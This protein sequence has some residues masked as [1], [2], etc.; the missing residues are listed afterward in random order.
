MCVDSAIASAECYLEQYATTIA[1][2]VGNLLLPFLFSYLTHFEEY[3][4]KTQLMIDLVRNIVIRLSGLM[5][6]IGGH[7]NSNK[8]VKQCVYCLL[9]I[10]CLYR[11]GYYETEDHQQACDNGNFLN[12]SSCARRICWETAV[13]VEFYRLTVLDL[14]TQILVIISLDIWRVKCFAKLEFNIPKHVL[15]IVY[16]QTICWMGLFFAP[17]LSLITL[18][19]LLSLFY[20]RLSYLKNWCQPS[21]TFYEVNKMLYKHSS[22]NF[23]LQ[24]S[25]TSSLLNIFL[26]VSF[27]FSFIPIAYILG[28]MSPSNACG[29]FRDPSITNYSE[30]AYYTDVVWNLVEVRGTFNTECFLDKCNVLQNWSDN[31]GKQFFLFISQT[32]VLMV[33]SAGT[34]Q[35]SSC[36]FLH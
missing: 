16:S 20:I 11:C 15:D 25:R 9:V 18:I 7:I 34:K 2:T 1:I 17:L 19:K 36:L 24:A 26:L 28:E 21:K 10:N 8:S 4:P 22:C 30:N 6:I 29:P 13:G 3:D 35:N 32:S 27:V 14:L 5:V 23:F 33:A 12:V 31:S